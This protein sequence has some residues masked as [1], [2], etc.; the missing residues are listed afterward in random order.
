M[1]L[2][3]FYIAILSFHPGGTIVSPRWNDR[4]TVVE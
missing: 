1:R 4:I 2:R 3:L